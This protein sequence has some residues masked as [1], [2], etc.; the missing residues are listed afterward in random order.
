MGCLQLR[1]QCFWVSGFQVSGNL[2]TN[3]NQ[4][5]PGNYFAFLL[6]DD[7]RRELRLFFVVIQIKPESRSGAFCV[8]Q[9]AGLQSFTVN[10]SPSSAL[11]KY[12]TS[13]FQNLL[14]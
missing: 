7:T 3:G 9:H 11:L 1:T 2:K 4:R 13:S 6:M 14:S 5:K 10:T 8:S 12:R